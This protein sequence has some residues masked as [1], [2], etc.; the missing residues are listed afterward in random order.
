MNFDLS[1]D[2]VKEKLLQKF[3]SNFMEAVT[4]KAMF[5]I[6]LADQSV[7]I[8]NGIVYNGRD[9]ILKRIDSLSYDK[10]VSFSLKMFD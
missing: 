2:T 7:Q 6:I 10:L 5:R 3:V 8:V 9:E 4:C 1:C